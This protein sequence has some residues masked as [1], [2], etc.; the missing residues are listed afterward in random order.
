MIAVA[1]VAGLLAGLVH[2]LV[3]VAESFL[4]RRRAVWRAFG[5]EDQVTA[6]AMAGVL[7]NQGFY[8]LFLGLGAVGGAVQLGMDDSPVLLMFCCA[9]MVAAALVLLITSRHLW[10]GSLVQ[11]MPPAVALAAGVSWIMS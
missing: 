1:V 4:W 6:D 7:F 3:W 11:G 8:N 5:V 9:F 10:V 2:V